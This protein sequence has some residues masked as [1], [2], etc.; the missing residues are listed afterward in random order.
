[1][2][3]LGDGC[4]SRWKKIVQFIINIINVKPSYESYD[5]CFLVRNPG[6][7]VLSFP[8]VGK[9]DSNLYCHFIC[10]TVLYVLIDKKIS[11]FA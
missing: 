7:R 5:N 8:R 9:L 1:M 11:Y 6:N 2:T 4:D 10:S 3:Q